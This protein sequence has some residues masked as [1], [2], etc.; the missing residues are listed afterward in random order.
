MGWI[1]I[2][3]VTWA[4]RALWM[5]LVTAAIAPVALM[6][7]PED[8]ARQYVAAVGRGDVEGAVALTGDRFFLNPEL[9]GRLLRMPEARGVLEWRAALNERW[10]TVSWR[11]TPDQREVH[12]VVEITNDAWELIDCR[13]MVE[14]VLVVRSGELI[15]EQ[16]RIE[17]QE[18]RRALAPFLAW[19]E[20]ERPDELARVWRERGPRWDAAAARGLLALLQEWRAGRPGV[21]ERPPQGQG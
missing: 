8:V 13:P 17:S 12:T 4:E 7:D 15:V 6:P 10:R 2:D 5:A 20:A 11:Y 3:R 1:R 16:A 19:A 14:V 21:A 18:L 9:D